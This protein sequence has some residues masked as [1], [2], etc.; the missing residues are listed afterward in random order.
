MLIL[1]HKIID[2]ESMATENTD[3]QAVKTKREQMMQRL[4]DRYPDKR[5]DDDEAAASQILDDYDQFDS[6]GKELESMRNETGK[7]T[8]LFN[9]NPEWASYLSDMAN[10][11]NPVVSFIR[12][13][14][15]NL[16]DMLDDP[17]KQE[18]YAAAQKEYMEKMAKEAA[19]EKE[20]ED[21][22]NASLEL[23]EQLEREGM[24]AD[25]IDKAFERIQMLAQN[26]IMGKFTREDIEMVTNA[27]NHDADVAAANHEGRV[28]GRND[29]IDMKLRKSQR[30]DGL[31]GA[32]G[33]RNGNAPR[34][35]RGGSI[36]DTARE[37]M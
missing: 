2:Q 21:N 29:K 14:G 13:Y 3:N 23:L 4:R 25:A 26:A 36:F 6:D 33:G 16:R 22:L 18:E 37:A 31:A 27:M 8:E 15:D 11:E 17:D 24:S 5:F 20:Y 32:M 12:R 7:L 28:A 1:E 30:G 9:K 34:P 19:F 35:N 10:G